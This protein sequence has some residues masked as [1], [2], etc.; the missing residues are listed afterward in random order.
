MTR[1]AVFLCATLAFLLSSCPGVSGGDRISVL[2]RDMTLR[3]KV[4]QLILL[5]FQ[6]RALGPADRALLRDVNPGGI[7]FYGRNMKDA[8]D[9]PAM[10][11]SINS[12]MKENK[13]PLFYAIDQEG[14]VVHRVEGQLYRPPSALSLGAAGSAELAREVGG[15]VG[16]AL[17]GLGIN[18]NLSPVL[19]VPEDFSSSPMATRSFGDNAEKVERLG[20]AYIRGLGDA[21]VLATAKHFPGIGRAFRDSH[22]GIPRIAWESVHERDNDMR[23]FRAAVRAGVDIVM[24]GHVIAEPGDSRKPVSLS[25]AWMSGTLRKE[26]GF[27]G[28]IIVDNIEMKAIEDTMPVAQAAVEAFLSGADMIMVSHERENQRAVF[29][30]L[31]DAAMKGRIPSERLEASLRRIMEAKERAVS[32]NRG[33]FRSLKEVSRSVAEESVTVIVRRGAPRV[34]IRKEGRVLYTGYNAGLFSEMESFFRSAG[35]INMPLRSFRKTRE[36]KF[37]KDFVK[38]FDGVIVDADYPDA[39]EMISL[40]R[41]AGKAYVVMLYHPRRVGKVLKELHP[42]QLLLAYENDRSQFLAALEIASGMREAKGKLPYQAVPAD[43][44]GY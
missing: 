29:D 35:R 34:L 18:V 1:R 13:A 12:V 17:R 8:S 7:V 39:R 2:I 11:S 10:I 33:S 9:I 42:G 24:A 26:M 16:S 19:D 3:Q 22:Y 40:C 32:G 21:G 5:G 28:L 44:Y 20:I 27:E 15:S 25:V 4:G 36:G 14:G 6:G 37:P 30:A 23:P 41:D 43:G 38:N 31:L